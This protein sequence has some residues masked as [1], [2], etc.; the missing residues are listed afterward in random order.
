LNGGDALYDAGKHGRELIS[1]A[2]CNCP[3]LPRAMAEPFKNLINT[4]LVRDAAAALQRA[5][6]GL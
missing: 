5:R 4:A 2:S 1:G 3:K 6:T